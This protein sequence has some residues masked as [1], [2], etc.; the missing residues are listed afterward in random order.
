MEN[1]CPKSAVPE[2]GITGREQDMRYCYVEHQEDPNNCCFRGTTFT[3]IIRSNLSATKWTEEDGVILSGR[4]ASPDCKD[5][6]QDVEVEAKH[7][8]YSTIQRC[9]SSSE[10]VEEE[11]EINCRCRVLSTGEWVDAEGVIHSRPPSP[12]HFDLSEEGSEVE[13]LNILLPYREVCCIPPYSP[14]S[15]ISDQSLDFEDNDRDVEVETKYKSLQVIGRVSSSPEVVEGEIGFNCRCRILSTGEW[16]DAEGVIHSRPPSPPEYDLPGQGSEVEALNIL[17]PCREVCC[18][19]PYSPYSYISDQSLDFEDNDRDVEVETKYKSLQVIGRVSS[20]PEQ[21]EEQIKIN[22]RCRILS[23]GEWVDAEGVIHSRPPSPPH[24]DLSEEGSEVEALNILLP[25]REVCCIPP[26]SPYSYISD[27]SLDFEDNDRDV[28]V[29]TKYKSLQGIGRVSSSPE[30]AEEQI[31]INCRC[32]ILST[33]EWVDAEGVIHSRPPSPP[34]FDLSEEGSEVEAL[35]ILLPYREVCCIPPYSPYSYISDQSLDFEDNDRDVEV[36]TK[37]KSLQVIGRVSSSPEQAEEQIKINCR[38]RILSTGEWVDAEGVIHSRP[39]SPPHFDLSE[40]GSEVEALNI[41]LPYREVCCIPPYSPYS[42]ISDQSLDF[43]DNDRDVEVETKY[44]SL[45][46]IGR[47][48][49]SPEVVEGE[50]GFNCRCRILSTGEWIDAEGVI[51]S[52]PPSPPEYD[53]PGQGSEVE[54]LNILLPCREVCCRPSYSPYSDIS[55]QSVDSPA[56]STPIRT[57]T[58]IILKEYVQT[59][60]LTIRGLR[61]RHLNFRVEEDEYESGAPDPLARRRLS[62]MAITEFSNTEERCIN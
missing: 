3:N 48:S 24:F 57:S 33:G 47:V 1:F 53:L 22:C 61:R 43:E 25:Y 5:N 56:F 31:K 62:L 15:Y 28:E 49:S 27:Q 26:Y 55:D 19:P 20:S 14:Y 51:H 35:N 23:T 39:P 59:P 36:E 60:T 7:K 38:C 34:H 37:Y 2:Y 54:A 16:I 30:Q 6:V 9:S 21:A 13:A 29:E 58:P 50:I 18:R 17:L 46:V 32:R 40:E 52:R 11:N 41:L 12:P 44:K 45:Q 42:Y 10:L 4:P 8:G